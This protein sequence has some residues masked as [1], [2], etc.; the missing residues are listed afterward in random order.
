MSDI[1]RMEEQCAIYARAIM[2]GD[3][4]RAALRTEIERLR[5]AA[6]IDTETGEALHPDS[7]I[8]VPVREHARLIAENNRL[9]AELREATEALDD[10][11]V[12]NLVTLPEA[13]R[14]LVREYRSMIEEAQQ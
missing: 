9:R 13:I 4:E 2:E 10:P 6:V 1:I 5:A 12:N 14:L 3:K 11:A 7:T 8:T